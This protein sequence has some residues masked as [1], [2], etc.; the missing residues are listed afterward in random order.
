MVQS[1]NFRVD[2]LVVLTIY[3]YKSN[4]DQNATVLKPSQNGENYLCRSSEYGIVVET[5]MPERMVIRTTSKTT[6]VDDSVNYRLRRANLIE[7]FMN[8]RTFD[9][10]KSLTNDSH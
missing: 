1:Y 2:D 7:R 3:Q 8:S 10:L 4:P 5:S 6:I 9:L